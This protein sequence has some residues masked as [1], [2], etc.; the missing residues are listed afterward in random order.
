MTIPPQVQAR[1]DY[2]GPE[3]FKRGYRPFFFL[4]GLWAVVAMPVWL[5]VLSG[6]WVNYSIP[7][8]LAWH[9]HEMVFGYALTVIMGFALTAIPNWTGRLPVQGLALCILS[10]TWLVARLLSL[11]TLL[12]GGYALIAA[13][14]ESLCLSGFTFIAAREIIMAKLWRNMPIVLIFSLL[15]VVAALSQAS[16]ITATPLPYSMVNLGVALVLTLIIIIGGRVIPSF[17]TNWMKKQN[18]SQ[19]PTP[20]NHFD[21][22]VIILS[23]ATLAVWV[24]AS[25]HIIAPYAYGLMGVLHLIRLSRWGGLKTTSE[26]MVFIMHLAYLWIPIG[27]LALAASGL[28][29]MPST[30]ALH[31]WT[32]GTVGTMTLA[33]MTRATLGHSGYDIVC[34]PL[35]KYCFILI[36]L[37]ALLRVSSGLIIL[38]YGDIAVISGG[39]WC[40]AF[41][42]FL[43]RYTGIFFSK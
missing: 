21:G 41:L 9:A 35:T 18:I 8:I 17:T 25:D 43:K 23:I 22:L 3:I 13:I 32:V 39:L 5:L 37:A 38:P 14:V 7:D 24:F 15:T 19:L 29:L 31:A 1:R 34:D 4:A 26:L 42:L 16:R 12:D 6:T 2:K 30:S 27:F 28:D 36:T 40:L 10:G 11:A 20:F 33:I